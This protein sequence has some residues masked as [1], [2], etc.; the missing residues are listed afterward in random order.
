MTLHPQ[1]IGTTMPH[2]FAG[3]YARQPDM[4]VNPHPAGGAEQ[5]AFGAPL[6]YDTG[7]A[8]V[9]MGAGSTAEQFEGLARPDKDNVQH[10]LLG[11]FV[12]LAD[13]TVGSTKGG[14]ITR[15]NQF[16]ID[17]NQNKQMI[18]TRLSGALTRIASAI[19]LEMPVSEEAA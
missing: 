11:L 7:G 17:F 4:I 5:I 12:N 3:S 16:D 13:Y 19:V 10:K 14:E 15:F 8:V 1:N 18:E 2:G 6:K 9:P